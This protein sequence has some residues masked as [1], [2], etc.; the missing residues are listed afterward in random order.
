MRYNGAL[1][2]GRYNGLKPLFGD[3]AESIYL[4]WHKVSAP[5]GGMPKAFPRTVKYLR[6]ASITGNQK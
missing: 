6:R 3:S 5:F 4:R 1:A 2:L